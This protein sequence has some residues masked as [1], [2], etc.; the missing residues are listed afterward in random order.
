MSQKKKFFP[1]DVY[2][3]EAI[4]PLNEVANTS[5]ILK[6]PAT[7]HGVRSFDYSP[8]MD[9]SIQPV[10]VAYRDQ[11]VRFLKGLDRQVESSTIYS[12]CHSGSSFLTYLD[13]RAKSEKRSYGLN[14]IS[15]DVVDGFLAFLASTNNSRLTQKGHYSH[16]KSVLMSL[17]RRG[18]IPYQAGGDDA[19]F[20]KNPFPGSERQLRG[21]TPL[22]RAETK[23]FTLALRIAVAPIFEQHNRPSPVLLAYAILLIALYTGRNT[24]ALLELTADCLTSHPK[25]GFFFLT[26]FKRRGHTFQNVPVRKN[27][28]TSPDSQEHLGIKAVVVRVI[29]RLIELSEP[30]RA[31][32]PEH[33]KN[34]IFLFHS[35]NTRGVSVR[36]GVSQISESTISVAIKTLVQDFQI[37]DTDGRPLRVSIGRLRKTF[38]NR[39]FDLSKDSSIAAAAIGSTLKVTEVNY[40]RPGEAAE[41]N[42]RFMGIALTNEL[43]SCTLGATDNT[44]VGQCADNL[45]GEY[46]P[47]NDGA[48]CTSFL[49]C[50][51][52]RD[53][54]VTGDD[55]YRLFS[56]YWRV[57][58]ERDRIPRKMWS[59]HFKHV[60]RLIDS[61]VIEMGIQQ[62][63]FKRESVERERERAR[64]QPHPFWAIASTADMRQFLAPAK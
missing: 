8:W 4:L 53:Y 58:A 18:Q 16:V 42:W 36:G 1:T 2:S 33:F 47:K 30:L 48:S 32:A 64:N 52:C 45:S 5:S 17:C 49:N 21:E 22:S 44:P 3:V 61:D 46:A 10:T 54:V 7:A 31:I 11:N 26:V 38:A 29:E 51:R 59:L 15:R 57:L 56:F 43:L 19:T 40:L 6:F 20:P 27:D 50:I 13:F 63:I 14:D 28:S 9:S 55:L 60:P 35:P 41:K 25:E 23:A 62:G 37:T 39:V 34:R 12:Y 24:T